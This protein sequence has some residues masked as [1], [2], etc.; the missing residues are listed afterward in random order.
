MQLMLFRSFL[1][2]FL[3]FLELQFSKCN[4][5]SP[6]A[7]LLGSIAADL[8]FANMQTILL[9]LKL[10]F[11]LVRICTFLL[12]IWIN[13]LAMNSQTRDWY[14]SEWFEPQMFYLY[15]T[16]RATGLVFLKYSFGFKAINLDL[17][18]SWWA[19]NI[20][21]ENKGRELFPSSGVRIPPCQIRINSEV[22]G[23]RF[24]SHKKNIVKGTTIARVECFCKSS[25]LKNYKYNC[26]DFF[27]SIT[28]TISKN[29]WHSEQ[30][31]A[32][33]TMMH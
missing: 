4:L 7:K 3:L 26:F 20:V 14:S 9:L 15:V 17:D 10:K 6:L 33:S 29:Q 18:M 23:R 32:G 21:L 27:W 8:R 13:K 16:S 28:Y 22:K 31:W 11:Y 12:F 24:E 1:S 19:Y 5:S 25:F 30:D 2:I